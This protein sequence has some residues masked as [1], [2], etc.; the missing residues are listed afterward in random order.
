MY[1]FLNVRITSNRHMVVTVN[2]GLTVKNISVR[3]KD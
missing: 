3:K 2:K 1:G